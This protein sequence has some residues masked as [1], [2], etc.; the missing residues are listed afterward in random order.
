MFVDMHLHEC[1]F[2]KDSFINLKQ[3]V[4]VA[5]ARGLNAVCITD[6][7]SMGLVDFAAEFSA[8]ENFPIFVGVVIAGVVVTLV[9]VLGIHALDFL[10]G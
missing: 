9:S 5:R 10:L 3:I 2:S 1:T 8:K 6:H 7:D 4:S